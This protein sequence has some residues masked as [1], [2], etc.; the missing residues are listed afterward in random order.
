MKGDPRLNE[1]VIEGY[2]A[3]LHGK[4]RRAPTTRYPDYLAW[5]LGWRQGHSQQSRFAVVRM[6]LAHIRAEKKCRP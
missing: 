5:E 4:P 3:A 2:S 6:Y 1:L